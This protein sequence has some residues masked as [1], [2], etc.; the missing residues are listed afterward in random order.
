MM[1]EKTER[2]TDKKKEPIYA[3]VGLI[4][5]SAAGFFM[6]GP[7]GAAFGAAIGLILG[8]GLDA[9]KKKEAPTV[10]EEE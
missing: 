8:A 10:T 6:G 5:G 2:A 3:G 9:Q 4:L 7:V 1:A